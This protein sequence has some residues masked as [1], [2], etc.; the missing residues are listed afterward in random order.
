LLKW[1]EEKG[2][3]KKLFSTL[4]I[5]LLMVSMALITFSARAEGATIWTDKAEYGSDETVTIFGSG[6]LANAQ[7]TI[8][9]P[10][11]SVATI[12]AWTDESGGFVA[13]YTLDGMTG[14]YTVTATDGANTA[15]TTFL[16]PP[17][18][19][20]TWSDGDCADIKVTAS[21]LNK[22]KYLLLHNIY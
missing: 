9:A 4:V 11:S 8:T 16:E 19:A 5:A 3:M 7:V 22:D 2:K 17:K 6:F 14:T 20:A 21:G 1:I 10:D 18:V 12:Y 13:Y 15:T